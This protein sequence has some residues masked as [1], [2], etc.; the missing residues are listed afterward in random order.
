[1]NVIIP[2]KNFVSCG[3]D[4][5]IIMA[6][7]IPNLEIV[8]THPAVGARVTGVDFSK[9]VSECLAQQIRDIFTQYSVLCFP[10]QDITNDHQ[11]NFAKI[12]GQADTA[13]RSKEDPDSKQSKRGVMYV[14]NIREDGKLIGVLPDG[15][16]HFHSDGAHREK[17][18]RATTLFAL[19]VPSFGGETRFAAMAAA[20]DALSR[21]Q[22]SS[23]ENLHARH[24]FN[25]NK[26]TREEMR[27]DKD[28]SYAIHPLVKIH[29]DSGRKSLYLSRL[30]TSDI[31]GMTTEESENLLIKLFA[32]CEKSEFVYEHKWTPGDLVIWDNRSVNHARND[33]PGDQRRL[34]RRYT[35][36]EPN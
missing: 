2:L 12:F 32:H 24:V 34:L 25:Y 21:S 11:A 18:Y 7:I 35:V 8:P 5:E 3:A 17:P 4:S 15:E 14:S 28:V 10:G 1:M 20:Y 29:P 26:T 22:R 19:E 16:M 6:K 31:I 27:R 23:L 9:P 30:M 13:D 33:F 36:S